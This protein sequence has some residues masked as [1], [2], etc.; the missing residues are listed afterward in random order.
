[1]FPECLQTIQSE[2]NH[3]EIPQRIK[4]I[5]D[6]QRHHEG[7]MNAVANDELIRRQPGVFQASRKEDY[8]RYMKQYVPSK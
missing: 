6:M 1:M 4:F 3:R 8:I 5:W 2:E 7:Y